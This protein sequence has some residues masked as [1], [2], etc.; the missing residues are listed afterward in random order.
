MEIRDLVRMANQISDFFRGYSHEEAVS[1]TA[2]HIRGFWDPR[3][4]RQLY[5]H[6]RAGGPI[7]KPYCNDVSPRGSH[8][9]IRKV[10]LAADHDHVNCHAAGVRQPAQLASVETRDACG[11][12]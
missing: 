5:A 4:R 9:T 12:S 2:A 1:G 10:S 7:A 3:M 11:G 6:A 8:A